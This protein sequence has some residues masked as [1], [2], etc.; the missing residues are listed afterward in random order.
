M[1]EHLRATDPLIADLIEREAQRQRQGLELIASE[2]HESGSHGGAGIG[3][4]E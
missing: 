1:L 3:F 4:D 2:L